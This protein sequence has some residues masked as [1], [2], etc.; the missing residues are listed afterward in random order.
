MRCTL[1]DDSIYITCTLTYRNTT[2]QASSINRHTKS[3]AKH[4]S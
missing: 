1:L 3:A 2:L 4:A